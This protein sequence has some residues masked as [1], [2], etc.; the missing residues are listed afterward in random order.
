MSNW[1]EVKHSQK[2]QQ[3]FF[4]VNIWRGHLNRVYNVTGSLSQ[5]NY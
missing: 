3:I 1:F 5:T 4:Q 2:S